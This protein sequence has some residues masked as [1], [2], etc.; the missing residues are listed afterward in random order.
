MVLF[1]YELM[2]F[3]VRLLS[4]WSGGEKNLLVRA[5]L[6]NERFALWRRRGEGN[7]M[8]HGKIGCRASAEPA[9]V[10][11]RRDEKQACGGKRNNNSHPSSCSAPLLLWHMINLTSV[12]ARSLGKSMRVNGPDW[13]SAE[14]RRQHSIDSSPRK[15]INFCGTS[16]VVF[17]IR[18]PPQRGKRRESEGE[19]KG[20]GRNAKDAWNIFF[21]SWGDETEVSELDSDEGN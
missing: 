20:N 4:S 18:L 21:L 12:C 1:L 16:W 7:F 9:A 19:I 11:K 10:I 13:C 2:K 5:L 14:K 15:I 17:K 3:S 6:S 8:G